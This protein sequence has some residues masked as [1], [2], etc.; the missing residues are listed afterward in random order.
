M[1]FSG[2]FAK[3]RARYVAWKNS[4]RPP[5]Q[6]PLKPPE[7]APSTWTMTPEQFLTLFPPNKGHKYCR[8]KGYNIQVIPRQKDEKTVIGEGYR[9]IVFC[10]CVMRRYRASGM[11]I[12]LKEEVTDG[13]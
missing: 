11:K 10:E 4:R 9:K 3:I 1:L 6:V 5:I 12:T 8:G 2:L 13:K 7:A